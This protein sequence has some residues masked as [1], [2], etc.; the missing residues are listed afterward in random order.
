MFKSLVVNLIVVLLSSHTNAMHLRK[1]LIANASTD[2]IE[3]KSHVGRE[4]VESLAQTLPDS[5]STTQCRLEH[6]HVVCEEVVDATLKNLAKLDFVLDDREDL[7]LPPG[8]RAGTITF[9]GSSLKFATDAKYPSSI[10]LRIRA[11]ILERDGIVERAP[12]TKNQAFLELKIKNPRPEFP[13]S[14]HKYRLL[15]PD[16]DL[17]ELINGDAH[18]HRFALLIDTLKARAHERDDGNNQKLINTM[19]EEI[20]RMAIADPTFIRPTIAISYYRTSKKYSAMHSDMS[21]DPGNFEITIDK[22]INA[23]YANFTVGAK[24][25]EIEKYFN[26]DNRDIYILARYPKT[27]RVIEFKQPNA[28]GYARPGKIRDVEMMFA[29]QR[30][31]YKSFVKRL[32]RREL[33]HSMADR[34]KFAHVKRYLRIMTHK[35]SR[36]EPTILKQARL[37]PAKKMVVK[38]YQSS[39]P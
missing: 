21:D 17:L 38:T 8:T 10:K 34:G 3:L 27:A 22:D 15:M 11:Y 23:H 7:D 28:V 32:E 25:L 20:Y 31:L 30:V 2:E 19:F 33:K 36:R 35:A 39:T 1:A 9:Y 24:S 14:V 37:R 29:S 5:N 13:L 12:L 4:I 18:E 6:K 16:T 26:D